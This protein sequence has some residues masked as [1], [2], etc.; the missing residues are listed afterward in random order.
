MQRV[1]SEQRKLSNPTKPNKRKEEEESDSSD[2]DE[3]ELF[4]WRAK[5]V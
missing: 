5:G 1:L 2:L 4:D 3:S